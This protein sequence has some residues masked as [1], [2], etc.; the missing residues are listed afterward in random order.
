MNKD[1]K[2]NLFLN[3]I[4]QKNAR[5]LENYCLRYVG[6]QAEYRGLVDESIQ[7]TFL[8]AVK[9]YD[10]LIGYTPSHIDAW[11][12][13]VCHKRFTTALKTYRRRHARTKPL[14]DDTTLYLSPEQVLDATDVFLSKI[15]NREIIDR[16]FAVFNDRER[17]ILNAH[18]I[19]ELSFE[20]IAAREHTTVGAVKAVLARLRA[21]AKK[22]AKENSQDF[23]VVI[24][25]IMYLVCFME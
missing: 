18:I 9:D 25:S 14:I 19:E 11:L 21:K 3:D 12:M 7:N 1:E 8:Q 17:R 16:L 6:Y 22:A 5:K 24:V 4:Y 20:D 23:F 10:K 15:T 2:R 13:N